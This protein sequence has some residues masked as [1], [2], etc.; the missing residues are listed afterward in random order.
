ME[1]EGAN[2]IPGEQ[3]SSCIVPQIQGDLAA[4]IEKARAA[5]RWPPRVLH[6]GNI[7]NNA[8]LNARILNEAGIPSDVLVYD[9]YHVMACP[10]WEE[11]DE[12]ASCTCWRKP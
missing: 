11:Y 6:I 1:Q 3:Q 9:Y 2:T 5:G 7:A 4:A 12:Y 10:E 8:Y